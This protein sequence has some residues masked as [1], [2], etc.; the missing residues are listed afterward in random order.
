M[1]KAILIGRLTKDVEIRTN[2]NGTNIASFTLAV[3]RNFTNKNGEREADFINCIAFNKNGENIAKYTKKGSQLA[4]NGR[5]QT[6]SYEAKD[7]SKRNA[8]EIIVD[9]F[10]FLDK[11]EDKEEGTK[12]LSEMSD[13]QIVQAVVNDEDPFK[14][15]G[16]EIELGP[17]DLPF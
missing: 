10:T 8:T 14:T 17:D 16:E 12:T 2:E 13:S 5:I 3:T 1:N 9:E 7:G 4:V 11:K 15:F 6:R